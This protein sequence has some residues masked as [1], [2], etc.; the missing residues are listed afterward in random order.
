MQINW[1]DA[2][3]ISSTRVQSVSRESFH[4][5]R[6]KGPGAGCGSAGICSM[7]AA[8]SAQFVI[9]TDGDAESLDLLKQNLFKF[10]A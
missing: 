4:C 2:L 8:S 7:V 3:G 10:G 5:C 1:L 9:A 6:Q